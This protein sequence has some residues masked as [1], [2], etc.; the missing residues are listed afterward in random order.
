MYEQR[1]VSY[2]F[3]SAAK[4]DRRNGWNARGLNVE[5]CNMVPSHNSSQLQ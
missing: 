1:R 4:A 3:D 2:V 5:R